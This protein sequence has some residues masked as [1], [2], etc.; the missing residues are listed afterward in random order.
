MSHILYK[1]KSLKELVNKEYNVRTY[2]YKIR[3]TW[4]VLAQ[5]N[6]THLH[7]CSS[8]VSDV[9]Y[10]LN[11]HHLQAGKVMDSEV[12]KLPEG[13]EYFFLSYSIYVL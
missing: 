6:I 7:N 3:Y 10:H 2:V 4:P 12:V 1:T 5:A 11:M 13:S 9:Q 8:A